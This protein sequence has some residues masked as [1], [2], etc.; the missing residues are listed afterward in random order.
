MH[1]TK[2]RFELFGYETELLIGDAED[3]PYEDCNFDYVYSMG[4]YIIHLILK[5]L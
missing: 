3:L 4:V 2:K 5:K 1:I